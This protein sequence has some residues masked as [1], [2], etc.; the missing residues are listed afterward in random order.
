MKTPIEKLAKHTNAI[1]VPCKDRQD[2]LSKRVI[3]GSTSPNFYDCGFSSEY[4][5]WTK[6]VAPPL[7]DD[8][9][10]RFEIGLGLEPFVCNLHTKKF[11]GQVEQWRERATAHDHNDAGGAGE[12]RVGEKGAADEGRLHVVL[13]G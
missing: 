13:L 11:G 6:F 1:L 3:G 5:E 8:G 10:E 4:A 9:C 12:Q 2:W 7:V